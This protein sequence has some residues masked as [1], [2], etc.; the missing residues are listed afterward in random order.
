MTT[1][2]AFFALDDGIVYPGF[3]DFEV[4]WNGFAA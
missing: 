4:E 1:L 2:A 3:H